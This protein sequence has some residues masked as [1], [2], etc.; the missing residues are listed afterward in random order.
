MLE[1]QRLPAV[2]YDTTPPKLYLRRSA[3]LAWLIALATLMPLVILLPVPLL[4]IPLGLILVLF[5][6]GYALTAAIFARRDDLDLPQ[7]LALSFGLSVALLPLIALVLNALPWGIRLW[8]MV[9]ALLIVIVVLCL[10]AAIRRS[11]LTADQIARPPA[12]APRAWL[13]TLSLGR[14]L[15]YGAGAIALIVAVLASYATLTNVAEVPATEFYAVGSRGLAEDY[16]REVAPNEPMQV[17]LGITNYQDQPGRYR[18][19][20]RSGTQQLA[21]LDHIDVAAGATWQ[22]SISYALPRV[23]DDQ[24]IDI[25]LFR[26]DQATPYRELRLWVNVKERLP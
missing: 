16:P 25:L 20:V 22:Q 23:G 15:S 13:A 21:A 4:R 17:Q 1:D 8:P 24:P 5:A 11:L 9:I 14:K 2:A 6:P 3:D 18:L 7:R 26:A 10:V 12:V 19:E